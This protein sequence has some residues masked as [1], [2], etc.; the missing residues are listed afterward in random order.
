MNV[1]IGK[2]IEKKFQDSGLKMSA[3]AE[4]INTGERNVYSIFGREDISAEMLTSISNALDFN[5][6]SFYERKINNLVNDPV[7][8][9]KKN[10]NNICTTFTIAGDPDD[11][12]ENFPKFLQSMISEAAKFGFKIK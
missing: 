10:Q 4:K 5:F 2:E 12:Y 6:F 8:V 1:H 11:Y 7:V 9:Y 3:F